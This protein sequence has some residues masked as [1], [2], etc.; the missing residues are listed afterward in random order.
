M[1]FYKQFSLG[2][3]GT[4]CY[5]VYDEA[6]NAV[7]VDCDG[8]GGPVISFVETEG[9][10]VGMILLTHGH[11]DHI[12]AVEALRA[13]YRCPVG[14][15]KEEQALLADPS[16][17]LSVMMGTR[18]SLQADRLFEEGD[19]FSVGT[20]DFTVL[21]TPGHT[22]GSVCY[23][24]ENLLLS[25]DTLFLG[26]CGRVDFPT[27]D[28]QKMQASLQRLAALPGDYTVLPG[29]EGVTTLSRERACNPYLYKKEKRRRRF[30]YASHS[31][32]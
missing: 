4:N 5:V 32:S 9:L 24:V 29:H 14:V 23:L 15:G 20:M 25:G 21:H 1:V 19:V 7:I 22:Q 18:L 26:S 27:G 31:A 30:F 16:L 13:L 6:K 28:A 17:N 2:Q 11:V 8:T 10:R 3:L 12:G